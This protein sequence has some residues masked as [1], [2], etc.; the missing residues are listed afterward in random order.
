MRGGD[1]QN[2]AVLYI[3]K[4]NI[5]TNFLRPLQMNAR[6]LPP[7]QTLCQ[8]KTAPKT[9]TTTSPFFGARVVLAIQQVASC[10]LVLLPGFKGRAKSE[11]EGRNILIFIANEIRSLVPMNRNPQFKN[12]RL[13]LVFIRSS[14]LYSRLLPH[15]GPAPEQQKRTKGR[16]L[17]LYSRKPKRLQYSRVK[18]SFTFHLVRESSNSTT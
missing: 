11:A 6:Y 13:F 17:N 5:S 8:E 18:R 14:L 15:P 4:T 16:R 10:L 9:P 12:L 1:L 7:F 3:G 2:H